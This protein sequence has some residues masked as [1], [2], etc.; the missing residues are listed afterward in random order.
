MPLLDVRDLQKW[1]G[2]RHVVDGVSFD[3]EQGEVVGLLGPNG[4]GKTTSFRIT[5]G[6]IRADGGRVIFNGQEVNQLAMYQRARTGMGYLA[7]DPSVF[8]QLSVEKNLLAILETLPIG[9]KERYRRCEDL[10]RQFGLTHIRATKAQRVSGGERRRL[11]IARCLVTQPKLIMLDEPFAGIDPKTV[12]EIQQSIRDLAEQY[13]IG[14]LLTD[15]N[16]RETLE[17]TDRA[18]IIHQGRVFAKGDRIAIL[19]NAEVRKHYLGERFD[20]GHLLDQPTPHAT[21]S[22]A[23][24]PPRM[25]VDPLFP[26]H[27]EEDESDA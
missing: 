20:A 6:L 11:E 4:A 23:L 7:Q 26:Y 25:V 19:R 1:Y 15:H 22:T 10:L 24:E 16:V 5:I 13:R 9:R 27:G 3:V 21:P 8:R 17:V 12:L 18:Y 14:I 2:R